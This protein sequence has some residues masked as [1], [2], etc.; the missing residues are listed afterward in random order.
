VSQIHERGYRH[1]PLTEEQKKTN[2]SKSKVRAKVEHVFGAWVMNL[3]GK[4]VRCIGIQRVRAQLGLKDLAYNV[5][6]YVFWRKKEL[7]I[8]QN[9]YA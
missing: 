8:L 5:R 9:Q 1:H 6:R 4:Q 3:G 2:R 7:Q